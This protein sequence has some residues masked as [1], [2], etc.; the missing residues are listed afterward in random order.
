MFKKRIWKP[1]LIGFGWLVSLAGLVV[2]MSFIEV[3]KAELVCKKVNVYIPG[4]QYFLDRQEVD[5]ILQTTSHSLIGRRL[6]NID[7]HALENKLKHNPFV[8]Y[9]KV[10]VDMDGVIQVEV[11][12][13]QP[14]LRMMNRFDQDFYIDQHGL[15][16]PL[17]QNFTARV[18]A[19]NGYID[20][21]FANKV[22]SLRTPLAKEIYKTADFI[23]KD[24]L[25]DAQIAQIYIN[26]DHEIELVPRVGN[27]RILLGNADSLATKFANLKVFYKQALPLVGWDAYKLI[28]IKFYNQVIGVRNETLIDS[29]KHRK[30]FMA[31]S[32]KKATINAFKDSTGTGDNT[33]VLQDNKEKTSIKN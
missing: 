18:L 32:V 8:E 5:N 28:N 4:N 17:S 27:Q 10:Y 21:L 22:D 13:R 24:S 26:Q 16:M 1:L 20:E 7:I 19:V 25:W 14:I 29:L 15:K 31:D 2:L 23:R 6:E 33:P 9:A 11:S 3:K 12:Q 30:Q